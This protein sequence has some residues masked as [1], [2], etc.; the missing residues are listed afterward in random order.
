MLN[1][2]INLTQELVKV[3]STTNRPNELQKVLHIAQSRVGK[4]KA[5]K[6]KKDTNP[7]LLI[8]NTNALPKKFKVILNGHLDVVEGK[9]EQF[10]PFVNQERIYG[11]GAD[12]MKAAT[13][14]LILL[15]NQIA[16]KVSYPL[17][18]QLTTDEEIGGHKG[19]LHQAQHGIATDFFITGETTWFNIKTQAKGVLWLQLNSIGKT[20]H[21]AYPWKGENAIWNLHQTLQKIYK[22]FTP[23]KKE[24]WQTTVNLATISTS[25]IT[26][27]KVP[28]DAFARLDIRYIPKD[29]NTIEN[30]IKHLA[31]KNVTVKIV[32]KEPCHYTNPQNEYVQKLQKIIK[33]HNSPKSGELSKS[34]GASDARHYSG[35]NMSAVEFG[36]IGSGLHSDSEWVNIKSLKD[37]YNILNHFL[38]SI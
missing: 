34:H 25:N 24:S 6:F 30:K 33:E 38:I 10:K 36:P 31:T 1:Q 5:K 16:S 20:A 23:P 14:V 28:E 11:R 3:R 17:G 9:D 2:I 7:S 4:Y 27:N 18:L 13:A 37:Y 15:F 35:L 21:G 12:D 22:E 8:Y 29:A 19:T 26:N 32:V